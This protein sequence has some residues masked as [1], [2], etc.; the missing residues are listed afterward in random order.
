MD[1]SSI[2]MEECVFDTKFVQVVVPYVYSKPAVLLDYYGYL[3]IRGYRFRLLDSPT[4]MK[5]IFCVSRNSCYAIG[6]DSSLWEI[7]TRGSCVSRAK[8]SNPVRSIAG[9]KSFFV[10][11]CEDNSI[12]SY[13]TFEFIVHD[14]SELEFHLCS[15]K[16]LEIY[17]T[18]ISVSC[19]ESHCIFLDETQKVF[20]FGSNISG[21]LGLGTQIKKVTQNILFNDKL[22][23]IES[24]CCSSH[25]TYCID[26]NGCL[27]MFGLFHNSCYFTPEKISLPCSVDFVCGGVIIHDPF[28]RD[29]EGNIWTIN[30]KSTNTHKLDKISASNKICT[31]RYLSN[32]MIFD[33]ISVH[34][35]SYVNKSNTFLFH[36]IYFRCL[37]FF[38]CS[39]LVNIINL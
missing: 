20:V 21:Q 19:G 22:Y 18:I 38:F 23:F 37:I 16:R 1:F 4:L 30:Q 33:M 36:I 3:W 12:W 32:H 9:G 14:K 7:D 39:Y 34:K 6:I 2:R 29:I 15:F 10:I 25:T 8:F 28:I 35:E 24:V 17:K 11:L 26:V 13:G 27:F 31:S 5:D